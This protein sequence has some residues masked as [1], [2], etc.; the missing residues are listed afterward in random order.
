M[1]IVALVG[2]G[3][4]GKTSLSAL[5]LD[6]LLRR[7][8]GGS[9]LAVDADPATTLHLALGLP[10]PR[11]TVADVRETTTLDAQTIRSLPPGTTPARY[12]AERLQQAG[13]LTV[14]QLR[15][16]MLHFIAMG[17][18]QGPG[19]YCSINSMLKT[20][21]SQVTKRYDLILV[22]N[23]AGLEHLSRYRLGQVDF[24]LTVTT[25]SPA[26]Q[27]V[28]RRIVKTAEVMKI[29][30]GQ[31]WMVENQVPLDFHNRPPQNETVMRLCAAEAIARLEMNGRPVIELA[32]NNPLRSTLQ[33]LVERLLCA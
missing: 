25:L 3:G 15:Q 29:E 4:V 12:V 5:L 7:G 1:T 27:A 32:A 31:T 14:H 13:V 11:A 24:F 6:E 26:A 28:A 16:K 9:V 17:Q 21:L 18:G 8:Y 2:K 23:E 22:D 19:C 20:V 10:E 30:I 33:P